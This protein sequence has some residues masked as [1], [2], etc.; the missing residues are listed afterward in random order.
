[1]RGRIERAAGMNA[2]EYIALVAARADLI[3]RVAASSAP[4]DALLMPTVAITAPPVS[5]FEKDEDYRRLNALILRNTSLIN[6]LDG[7]A[8]TV[9]IQKPGSAPVGLM[10]AGQRGQDRHILS[11]ALGI[12]DALKAAR[13]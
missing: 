12:E 10:I 3:A 6:F 7:C 8:A 9:P 5:A 1:M 2:V 13:Q 11:V 4:Y